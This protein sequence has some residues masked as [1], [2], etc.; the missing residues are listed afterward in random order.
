M[1]KG[2]KMQRDFI[3]HCLS[4]VFNITTEAISHNMTIEEFIRF[5]WPRGKEGH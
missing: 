5:R 3:K 2:A 1:S 4:V